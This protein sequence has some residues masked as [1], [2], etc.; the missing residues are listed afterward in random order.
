MK[1]I[2]LTPEQQRILDPTGK[3]FQ[4]MQ[5]YKV[6]NRVYERLP[7]Y[8]R[9]FNIADWFR[10]VVNGN[11]LERRH[12]LYVHYATEMLDKCGR[13]G[14][15]FPYEILE[16]KAEEYYKESSAPV[17]VDEF[18]RLGR[19]LLLQLI[20]D[21]LEK[22]G[23]PCYVVPK[24]YMTSS[25]LKT[26]TKKG[27]WLAETHA[28]KYW[29]HPY[30]NL[31]GHRVMRGKDRLI[32][33]DDVANVR[34]IEDTLS[35][36]RDW[37]RSYL[38]E[39]FG[40]WVN[41]RIGVSPDITRF[42]LRGAYFCES[43]YLGMDIHFSRVVVSEIILPIYEKLM[44]DTFLSF[45]SFVEE[46]FEQP[47]YMGNYL[48]TGLHNL[49]SGQVIT[50]DFETIYTV[51]LYIGRLAVLGLLDNCIIKAIGDDATVGLLGC[52]KRMPYY[53]MDAVID[54][55]NQAN[56]IIHSVDSG[57]SAIR[58][59]ETIFCRKVYYR[60]GKKDDNGNLIGAYPS[61]LVLNNILQPE[62]L[63]ETPGQTAV[64][65]LQRMDNACGSPEYF[66]L[67]QKVYSSVQD[68]D[69]CR[70]TDADISGESDKD[71][72]FK[73]YGEKWNPEASLSYRLCKKLTEEG[74]L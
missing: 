34:A 13:Q 67:V 45:A 49:F 60:Q 57:K 33:M 42:V 43:D 36:V 58:Q 25:G 31:P 65:T 72:W 56:M 39:F 4:H 9:Q 71:W 74:H 66:H 10:G 20:T 63:S 55:S 46:L 26:M 59:G 35:A 47:L 48:I 15:I 17:H 6:V 40:A 27:S 3:G 44:P 54:S 41:P 53:L 70:V 37:L 1:R 68:L 11:N 8:F 61:P 7:K 62:R 24:Y 38:P 69:L 32:F 30:P 12:S 16:S 18:L 64:A 52:T 51:V 19:D 2:Y 28:S 73:V 14:G 29:I 50:N 21:R 5:K 22:H 23:P